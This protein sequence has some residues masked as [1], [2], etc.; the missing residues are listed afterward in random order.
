MVLAQKK[1][2]AMFQLDFVF[3]IPDFKEKP[4]KV[5]FYLYFFVDRCML[6]KQ[7]HVYRLTMPW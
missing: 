6:K 3:V 1:V 5:N 2:H 7:I 4:V